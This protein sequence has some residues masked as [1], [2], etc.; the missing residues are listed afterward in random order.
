MDINRVSLVIVDSFVNTLKQQLSFFM[1]EE[2]LINL[3]NTTD[4]QGE[5][6]LYKLENEANSQVFEIR[7]N[8]LRFKENEEESVFTSDSK[9]KLNTFIKLPNMYVVPEFQEW[10]VSE[11]Q[12]RMKGKVNEIINTLLESP[13]ATSLIAVCS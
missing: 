2:S 13:E 6:L 10:F 12:S 3:L 4:S 5:S 8:I 7:E 11:V 9:M 1:T